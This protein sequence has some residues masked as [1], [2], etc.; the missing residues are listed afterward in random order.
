MIGFSF[1]IHEILIM[2]STVSKVTVTNTSNLGITSVSPVVKFTG[3]LISQ[4]VDLD[5]NKNGDLEGAEILRAVQNVGFDA[6]AVFRGFNL[7]D[8]KAQVA[9]LDDAERKVLINEFKEV[10]DL[11]NDDV[12]FLVEDVIEWL[13]RGATL[14]ARLRKTFKKAA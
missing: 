10:F 11:Q 14:V 12:E 2:K 13:E 1:L 9:D 3:R 6:F 7:A 8:F 5:E 4:V